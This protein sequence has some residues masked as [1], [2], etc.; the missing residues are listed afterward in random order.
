MALISTV[1]WISAAGVNENS[2]RGR[3]DNLFS[4]EISIC[5]NPK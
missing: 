5:A 3:T 4:L 1:E 2:F